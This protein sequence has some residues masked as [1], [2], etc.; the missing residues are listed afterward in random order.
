MQFIVIDFIV[1]KNVV[2]CICI[3][4]VK[5]DE[6]LMQTFFVNVIV[7]KKVVVVRKTI[8]TDVII[9]R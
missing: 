9:G 4:S 8:V 3:S 6:I 2:I 7:I 5:K 1:R